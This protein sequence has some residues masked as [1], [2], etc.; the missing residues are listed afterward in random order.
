MVW[1]KRLLTLFIAI[2]VLIPV[3]YSAEQFYVEITP[4]NDKIYIDES[5]S[6]SFT[7][8]I[9]NNLGINDEFRIYT[10]DFPL[11]SI[12]SGPGEYSVTAN[13]EPK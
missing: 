4:I 13:V 1:S 7:L 2:F 10:L 3:V 8:R 11:W 6:A 5:E 12:Y 9:I